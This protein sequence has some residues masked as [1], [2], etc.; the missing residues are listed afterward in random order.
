[1]AALI[2]Q[3]NK[4]VRN[5]KEEEKK[6]TTNKQQQQTNK[7]MHGGKEE[8]REK[9]NK[10]TFWKESG[11]K[12]C[13]RATG[14]RLDTRNPCTRYNP[15][16]QTTTRQGNRRSWTTQ[17]KER[18][19]GLVKHRDYPPH[20]Y[21]VNERYNSRNQRA[22]QEKKTVNGKNWQLAQPQ[23]LTQGG[24]EIASLLS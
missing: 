10:N 8:E 15:F 1:M 17:H 4:R 9:R 19:S 3:A 6:T 16:S 21:I 2:R 5:T 12:K 14:R 13:Q 23:T 24:H 20:S 7:Q 11:S 18:M 22:S